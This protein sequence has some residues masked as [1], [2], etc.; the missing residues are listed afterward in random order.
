LQSRLLKRGVGYRKNSETKVKSRQ[1]LTNS[2]G[3]KGLTNTKI[4]VLREQKNKSTRSHGQKKR[5]KP[6]DCAHGI[7]SDPTPS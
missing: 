1:T 7:D 4:F 5:E 6:K 2:H 3:G